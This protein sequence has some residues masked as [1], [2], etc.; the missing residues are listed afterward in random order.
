MKNNTTRL[1]GNYHPKIAN[2]VLSTVH[3]ITWQGNFEE[4][5]QNVE[6]MYFY[7]FV[8][9]KL[10]VTSLKAHFTHKIYQR[11]LWCATYLSFVCHP[12]LCKQLCTFVTLCFVRS[13]RFNLYA[14]LCFIRSW[15]FVLYVRDVLICTWHFVLYMMLHFVHMWRSV[16]YVRDASFCTF[17]MLCLYR[18]VT[19]RFVC[20]WCFIVW[21]FV[22]YVRDTSFCTFVTLCTYAM[23]SFVH[24]S[25]F[26]LYICDASFST[27]Y[28]VL[29][30]HDVLFCMY[31]MLRFV[32]DAS[33]VRFVCSW[34]FVLYVT[35][36]FERDASFVHAWR[37]VVYIRDALFCMYAMIHFVCS[38]L[39]V[40]DWGHTFLEGYKCPLTQS[41]AQY[42]F[43]M[44]PFALNRG[45]SG[46]HH[47][48]SDH[49]WSQIFWLICS[50]WFLSAVHFRPYYGQ[51]ERFTKCWPR[52]YVRGRI[53]LSKNVWHKSSLFCTFVTLRC[54]RSWRFVL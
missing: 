31:L 30:V 21:R 12:L 6:E 7:R 16:L 40:L 2:I 24:A 43:F 10:M 47:W 41:S 29:Y 46:P 14:T 5:S 13:W 38:W 3:V 8:G 53:Y 51:M 15:R 20:M 36:Y 49:I 25:H 32:R 1:Q 28:F 23:L 4:L 45:G 17:M 11:F 18:Y 44:C 9:R 22:L 39:S 37:F 26:V 19:H 27:W 52:D 35:L 54:V 50:G 48:K 42:L 34:H 33:L